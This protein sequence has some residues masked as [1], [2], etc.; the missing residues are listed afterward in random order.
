MYYFL[1]LTR[2]G[3]FRKSDF[4]AILRGNIHLH[5]PSTMSSLSPATDTAI[6]KKYA[7]DHLELKVQNKTALQEELGWTPEPKRAM[8]CLP[9]G[10]SE[11]LGGNLLK[12]LIPGLLTLPVEMV[13]LGKGSSEF[14]AYLTELAKEHSHRIAIVPNDEK[15]IRKMFAAADMALFLSD[16][17]NTPELEAALCYGTIPLCP[18]TKSIKAYDPNQESGEGFLY[19]K[20][21]VWHAYGSIV[22]ALETFRFPYDWKTIQKACMERA[23]K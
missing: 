3:D 15:N 16:A 6:A 5:K 2:A 1:L 23:A 7:A 20:E 4:Y 8:V 11:K 12:E 17:T 19:D 18:L 10:V 13:I 21:T 9:M 22:R 14:G